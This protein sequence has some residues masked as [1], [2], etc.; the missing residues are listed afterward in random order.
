MGERTIAVDP[1]TY[2][3]FALLRARLSARRPKPLTWEEFL[4]VLLARERR[5][6]EIISW[7]YTVGIFVAITLVLLWPVYVYAPRLIPLVF[8]VGAVFAAI[9]AYVLSP[10]S[11]RITRPFKDAPQEVVQAL[12]TLAQKAGLRNP[13]ELRIAET[14]EI[15]AM[16][17]SSFTGGGVCL[18]RGTVDAYTSGRISERE[19]RAI[20]GHEIGHLKN[21]DSLSDGLALSWVSVFNYFGNESIRMGIRMARLGT[22]LE[23][24]VGEAARTEAGQRTSAFFQLMIVFSGWFAV[25]L[26]SLAK[27]LAKGA[28][29]LAFQLSRRQEYAADDV[30]AEL[31]GPGDMASALEKI[32]A[33][34]AEFVA[35][36]LAKLP[37]ADR[38]QVQPRNPTW[39]EALWDSHPTTEKR[40]VRQKTVGAHL[41]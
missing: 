32:E 22:V 31:T 10:Q 20:I 34:N 1:E 6:N 29:V 2:E 33:L 15:N 41:A 23:G 27:L 13:P 5:K 30:A 21:R 18:T 17:Y 36:E 4:Q 12:A 24:T 14:P 3:R 25:I 19:L 35:K 39:V 26:G 8:L 40:V 9:W 11:A 7:A 16:A 37:Y 28:S 38:W